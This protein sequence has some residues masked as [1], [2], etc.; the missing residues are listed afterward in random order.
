MKMVSFYHKNRFVK[1][2]I[3]IQDDKFITIELIH[4][5]QGKNEYWQAGEE[6]TFSIK[7]CKN[8][9]SHERD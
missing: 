5:Y 7:N 9:N 2:Y 8:I 3:I 6:K 1:G 4:D